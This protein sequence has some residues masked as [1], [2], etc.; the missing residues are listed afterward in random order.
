MKWV[1]IIGI[2]GLLSLI[3]LYEWPKIEKTEKKERWTF[4]VLTASSGMLA[5]IL[6]LYPTIPGPSQFVYALFK[7]LSGILK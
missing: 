5:I 4:I 6:L 1:S 7:P 3:F 2:I